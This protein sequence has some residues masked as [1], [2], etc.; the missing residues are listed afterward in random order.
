MKAGIMPA[1][2][3]RRPA[4]EVMPLAA[5]RMVTVYPDDSV[6]S[7]GPLPDVAGAI[8]RVRPPTVSDAVL[9]RVVA[10]L[11]ETALTVRVEGRRRPEVVP[12]ETRRALAGSGAREVVLGMAREAYCDDRPALLALCEE[13]L[14]AA[15]M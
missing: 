7:D 12:A 4:V 3:P 14:S 13:I 1:S 8:V 9:D 5:I 15:G 6:W 11:R 2:K 10:S